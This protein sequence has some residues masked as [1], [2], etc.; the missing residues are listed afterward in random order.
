[1]AASASSMRTPAGSRGCRIARA[2]WIHPVAERRSGPRQHQSRLQLAPAATPHALGDQR[3]LIL[4][5]RAADLQQQ[6]VVRVLAHGAVEKPHLAAVALQL[7][8]QQDL[9]DVVARQ[10]VRR[11]DQ[12]QIE[13]AGG[14]TVAQAIETRP[15]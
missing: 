3:A 14:G 5:D 10:P 4:R 11:G 12:H 13:A 15:P 2:V 9:M 1:M 8:Q 6:L 7:R